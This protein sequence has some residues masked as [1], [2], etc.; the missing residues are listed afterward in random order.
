MKKYIFILSTVLL[1][2]CSTTKQ[3]KRI[4]ITSIPTESTLTKVESDI[5][6]EFLDIELN[7]ELYKRY[8]DFDF[9][10]IEEALKKSKPLSDYEFNY[11]YKNSWG[12]SI[13][14]WILDSL[15]IKKIKDEIENE[16][17]YHWKESDFK[18][19]K[20]TM[21]KYEKLREIIKKGTYGSNV[22]KR[23]I[24]YLS[25]PLII[26]ENNAFISFEIGNGQLGFNS[27]THFT[28]LMRKINNKWVESG[29]YE[30][31]AF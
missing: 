11:K 12:S 15:Q 14:E 10:V 17:V 22:T 24:I 27:I 16:E 28:V 19:I 29:F 31:G 23:L 25:K 30:D 8:K 2:S 9:F 13:T 21:L 4:G 6:N 20:T 1:F 5:V 18:S 26:N 7:K 3:Q